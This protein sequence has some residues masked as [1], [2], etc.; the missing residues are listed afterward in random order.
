MIAAALDRA[1]HPGVER[2]VGGLEAEDENR[3][4]TIAGAGRERL[5]G[6]EETTVRR[7][8]TALAE[9]MHRGGAG[10]EIGKRDRCRRAHRRA[11][12]QA[13]PRLGDDAENALGADE[14]AVGAGAGTGAGQAAGGD[15]A[16]RRH[17][18]QR[19]DEVVDVRVERGEVAAGAGGDP[20]TQ[21][22]QL[23]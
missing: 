5:A 12:L 6:I 7:I 20:A 17:H 10:G 18:A 21:R 16:V 14:Q 2:V 3:V 19:L 4:R 23:E 15:D 1:L 22:R 11:V 13:H 8:K 9:R